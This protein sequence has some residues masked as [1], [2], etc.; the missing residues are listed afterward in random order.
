MWSLPHLFQLNVVLS[1]PNRVHE[2]KLH[3]RTENEAGT[4]EKPHLRHLNVADLGQRFAL[5][6]CQRNE[7]QHGA[8]AQHN[9]RCRLVGLQPKRHPRYGDNHHRRQEVVHQ[10]EAHLTCQMHAETERTVVAGKGA[11]PQVRQIRIDRR[12]VRPHL[13]HHIFGQM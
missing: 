7:R 1:P 9:A 3:Q 6:R 13:Q 5:R 8:G 11:V 10:I 12:L 2:R 4:P